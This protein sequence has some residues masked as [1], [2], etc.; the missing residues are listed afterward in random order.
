MSGV[1]LCVIF[2]ANF[3]S[4]SAKLIC[5]RGSKS[6]LNCNLERKS[7]FRK[8]EILQFPGISN[9]QIIEKRAEV[10]EHIVEFL[11]RVIAL[12]ILF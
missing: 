1:I 11:Y 10:N 4:V 9:V 7:L 12:A 5:Y 2:L 6:E 3:I 8:T